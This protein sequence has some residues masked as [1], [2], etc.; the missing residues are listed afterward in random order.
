MGG[1]GGSK[2][3]G[4]REVEGGIYK[5][6]GGGGGGDRTQRKTD[7]EHLW[8]VVCVCVWCVCVCW[9]GGGGGSYVPM[10]GKNLTLAV[11]LVS[12]FCVLYTLSYSIFSH[13]YHKLLFLI[14][15][16]SSLLTFFP[17]FLI[18]VP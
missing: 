1:G 13:P 17:T 16:P 15:P 7:K 6:G 12:D 5:E 4:E 14:S 11:I 18:S 8:C 9:G 2:S 10:L 3:E